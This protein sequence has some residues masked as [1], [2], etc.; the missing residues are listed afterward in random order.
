[1]LDEKILTED[2]RTWEKKES[3][4][5]QKRPRTDFIVCRCYILLFHLSTMKTE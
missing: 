2:H 3:M 4:Q 1:M 5:V